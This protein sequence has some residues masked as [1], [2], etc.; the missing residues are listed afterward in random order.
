MVHF[1]VLVPIVEIFNKVKDANLVEVL[2]P[3]SDITLILK[4]IFRSKADV[5]NFLVYT[6]V[7]LIDF[8]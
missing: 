4:V 8:S 7:N 6:G 3:A 1:L 5:T 2:P